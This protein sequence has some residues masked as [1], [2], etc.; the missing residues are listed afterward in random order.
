[1]SREEIKAE[2]DKSFDRMKAITKEIEGLLKDRTEATLVQATELQ[3]A[4]VK[5]AEYHTDMAKQYW[6]L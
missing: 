5:V 3:R 6:G 4:W 1:M 2:M